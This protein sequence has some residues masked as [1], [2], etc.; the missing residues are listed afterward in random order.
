MGLLPIPAL[1]RQS[2]NGEMVERVYHQP[3]SIGVLEWEE[4]GKEL[5][6]CPY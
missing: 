4:G 6:R 3:A 2:E 5:M 1:V